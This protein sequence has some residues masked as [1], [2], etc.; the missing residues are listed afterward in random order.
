[1]KRGRAPPPG[2]GGARC[3]M[4]DARVL[5]REPRLEEESPS[6]PLASGHAHAAA[7]FLLGLAVHWFAAIR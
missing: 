7:P 2:H 3:M 5:Q 6:R 4:H 1:M